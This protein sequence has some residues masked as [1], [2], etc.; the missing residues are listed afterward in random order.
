M[1]IEY[2][3]SYTGTRTT[4]EPAVGRS[5]ITAGT[6]I[7]GIERIEEMERALMGRNDFRNVVITNWQRFEAPTPPAKS[8]NTGT[9][10]ESEL[11]LCR[12]WFN[13]VQDGNPG[14]LYREDYALAKE[15]YE[16]VGWR[17]PLS[18]VEGAEKAPPRL[19]GEVKDAPL[20]RAD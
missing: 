7:S 6:S 10:T 11:H 8:G 14:Y 15:I 18:V 2:F 20:V 17:V 13:S 3:V 9:M 12:Q 1:S 16:V 5:V 4:G 19:D